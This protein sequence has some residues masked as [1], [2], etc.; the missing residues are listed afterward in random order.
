M[1]KPWKNGIEMVQEMILWGIG[2]AAELQTFVVCYAFLIPCSLGLERQ[3]SLVLRGRMSSAAKQRIPAEETSLECHETLMLACPTPM[4]KA[5]WVALVSI[6]QIVQM[7]SW[8]ILLASQAY[9]QLIV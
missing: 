9:Q 6:C 5:S 2:P 3:A 7:R 4:T 1:A 8:E